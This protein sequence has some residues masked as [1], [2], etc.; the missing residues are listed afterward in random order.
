MLI[1][2]DRLELYEFFARRK[3]VLTGLNKNWFKLAVGA[4]AAHAV[5]VQV[6]TLFS[7][8]F[9]DEVSNVEKK[10]GAE[11]QSEIGLK[12]SRMKSVNQRKEL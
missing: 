10:L 8:F 12:M 7:K 3:E 6:P 2:T 9:G 4:T 5:I 11:D 1:G